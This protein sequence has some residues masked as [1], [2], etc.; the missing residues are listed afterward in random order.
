MTN[1]SNPAENPIEADA[2][3]PNW[4]PGCGNFGILAGLKRS[5]G[6]SGTDLSRTVVV[7]GIGCGANLP[8]W[9]DTF[10][11][12]TLHGRSLPVARGIKLAD[13]GLEVIVVAGDGDTYGIGLGH[14]LHA[15]RADD[16]LVC[17]VSNNG[18]YGLTKGQASPTAAPGQIT[19]T[20]PQ[21]AGA[22]LNPLALAL[23]AGCGYVARGFAADPVGLAGLIRQA[24]EH[25]GFTFID[26]IQQC[27]SY[28]PGKDHRYFREH[29]V[30]LAA[31]GHDPR[32]LET[33][34]DLARETTDKIYTGLFYRRP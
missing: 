3:R 15:I 7:G 19:S 17:L 4:C 9:M 26:I 13:P 33:A 31:T 32:D 14:F 34:L 25:K 12:I 1:A 23:T 21:G 6:E 16:D 10:S 18:V 28:N 27:P 29:I 8:N 11:F 2:W 20:T 5:L 30:D 22:P 24:M